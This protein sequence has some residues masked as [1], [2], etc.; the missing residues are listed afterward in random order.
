MSSSTTTLDADFFVKHAH[1]EKITILSQVSSRLSDSTVANSSDRAASQSDSTD[2]DTE[3]RPRRR[4][5]RRTK[6]PRDSDGN[7]HYRCL[8]CVAQR[9]VKPHLFSFRAVADRGVAS[10]T[11]HIVS[12]H[13]EAALSIVSLLHPSHHVVSAGRTVSDPLPDRQQSVQHDQSLALNESAIIDDTALLQRIVIFF[14]TNAIARLKVNHPAFIALIKLLKPS[15]DESILRVH[16]YKRQLQREAELV[17][18]GLIAGLAHTPNTVVTLAF[19]SWTNISH[20]KIINILLLTVGHA[21]YWTSINCGNQPDT[22]DSEC[23][24]IGAVITELRDKHHIEVYGIV[25]DNTN[26][27]KAAAARLASKF[28]LVHMGCAAHQIQL[29]VHRFLSE[30]ALAAALR[31]FDGIIQ[32]FKS[33]KALRN[34]LNENTHKRILAPNST[35]WSSTYAAYCRIHELRSIL[36]SLTINNQLQFNVSGPEWQLLTDV[37][38]VLKFFADITNDM[39]ADNNHICQT[40]RAYMAINRKLASFEA[41]NQFISPTLQSYPWQGWLQPTV[42]RWSQEVSTSEPIRAVRFL[43][44]GVTRRG[45]D[46]RVN[47]VDSTVK[48]ILEVGTSVL[49][50]SE[51]Y[52][53]FSPIF[54]TASLRTQ[55][56]EFNGGI[57]S[58]QL[59]SEEGVKLAEK[60][61]NAFDYWA[62]RE[63]LEST[64]LLASFAFILLRIIASEAAVERSFSHQGLIHSDLCNRMTIDSVVN[65]MHVRWNHHSEIA[66]RK[67]RYV[68]ECEGE[69]LHPSNA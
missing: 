25:C 68:A 47:L 42:N 41:S 51:P 3:N 9:A 40:H 66:Y 31:K 22:T 57:G 64:K 52:K 32:S 43:D 44:V 29:I 58:F 61:F 63:R 17:K 8:H 59:T 12:G 39:Q 67:A 48:W 5:R 26:N 6:P 46:E 60:K 45:F 11:H 27:V 30:P 35:R 53:S 14:C 36:D 62:D 21:H 49:S 24:L 1:I 37:N 38:S 10:I 7:T 65:E 56:N 23:R 2:S 20:E 50:K 13:P 15:L 4:K 33:T 28:G 18:T 16:H 34:A 55:I 54:I 19:D 69:E